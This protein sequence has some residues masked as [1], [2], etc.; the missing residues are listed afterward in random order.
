MNDTIVEQ[1]CGNDILFVHD[2]IGD[3][4]YMTGDGEWWASLD[5]ICKALD[6]SVTE[7]AVRLSPNMTK[8]IDDILV[9]NELGIYDCLF[10]SKKLDAVSFRHWSSTVLQKMRKKVGLSSHEVL[11]M[12]E[13]QTQDDIDHIL[14]TLFWDE[15]SGRLMQSITVQGGDVEQVPLF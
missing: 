1:W 11:R 3:G 6:L 10:L 14:D 15:D 8:T 12:T 7:T 5:D 2:V 9:V 13:K 4:E